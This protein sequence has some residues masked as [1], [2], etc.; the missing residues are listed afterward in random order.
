MESEQF[1][2]MDAFFSTLNKQ[3][4]EP[5]APES[6]VAVVPSKVIVVS[7]ESVLKALGSLAGNDPET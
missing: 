3:F 2:G 5:L 4:S 6:A 7:P 1:W